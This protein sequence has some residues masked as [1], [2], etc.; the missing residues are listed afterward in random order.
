[1]FRRFFSNARSRDSQRPD[2]P[3]PPRLGQ[4]STGGGL[5]WHD[6]HPY[7]PYSI[8]WIRV[9][10]NFTHIYRNAT[11][12]IYIGVNLKQPSNPIASVRSRLLYR[13]QSDFRLPG[14]DANEVSHRVGDRL[15]EV[16]LQ[17]PNPR[18]VLGMYDLLSE[19]EQLKCPWEV[20]LNACRTQLLRSQLILL[21][22][23]LEDYLDN[24]EM[25]LSL[26]KI[27]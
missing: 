16:L 4:S 10:K 12:E 5:S 24:P 26:G 23:S 8:Y 18:K 15:I 22:I 3:R 2:S 21:G 20:A 27:E 17:T 19:G 11:H 6:S 7:L 25:Y 9:E 14:M 13:R 1:M